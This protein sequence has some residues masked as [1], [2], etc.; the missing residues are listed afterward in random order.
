MAD[1]KTSSTIVAMCAA[2][3]L[4]AAVYA[5]EQAQSKAAAPTQG[6]AKAQPETPAGTPPQAA[7]QAAP[8]PATPAAAQAQAAANPTAAAPQGNADAG[9]GKSS[10][11]VGCHNIPGYKTAFPAVYSVPKLDGQHAAYMVKALRAYK[12]GERTHPS[13]RGV[14]ASLSDQDMADL[15]AFYSTVPTQ[16]A[17]R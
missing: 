5:A 10:M 15:A 2:F 13:M 6:T 16:S 9:R 17:S 8:A 12:S 4:S 1:M 7:P 3:A 11:C 14:A